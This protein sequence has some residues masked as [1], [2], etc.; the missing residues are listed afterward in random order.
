MTSYVI[1]PDAAEDMDDIYDYLRKENRTAAAK[2]ITDLYATFDTI[3]DN[4]DMGRPYEDFVPGLQDFVFR[5][6]HIFYRV[7][8]DTI[9]IKRVIHGASDLTKIVFE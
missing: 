1:D 3:V 6:Y 5:K 7:T 2:L 4:P 9:Y 8:K